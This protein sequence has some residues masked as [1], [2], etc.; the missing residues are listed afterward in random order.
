MQPRSDPMKCEPRPSINFAVLLAR[1]GLRPPQ[2][3]NSGNN[4]SAP[5]R[6]TCAASRRS[7]PTTV[8]VACNRAIAPLQLLDCGSPCLNPAKAVSRPCRVS[9]FV[10]PRLALRP[11]SFHP[12]A[13]AS[14][15]V[16]AP[17]QFV[18]ASKPGHGA[19]P[20]KSEPASNLRPTSVQLR[21]PSSP[22]CIEIASSQFAVHEALFTVRSAFRC[23]LF[24][25]AGNRSSAGSS[26]PNYFRR[27][28]IRAL[29]PSKVELFH[30]FDQTFPAPHA[31][32]SLLPLR[33]PQV[34]NNR[35]APNSAFRSKLAHP[36]FQKTGV[37]AKLPN[38]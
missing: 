4:F 10:Q 2:P 31:R 34:R 9:Y 29:C 18:S 5:S 26:P 28:T 6:V 36:L 11:H 16:P 3:P 21:Q 38:A 37:S 30:V 13:L 1:T 25:H 32:V 15:V 17:P 35:A 12:D 7:H 20:S 14:S 27:I 24:S 19:S 23:K 8:A 22:T 33:F